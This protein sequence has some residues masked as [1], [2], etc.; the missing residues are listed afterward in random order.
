MNLY[1]IK[2]AEGEIG[3]KVGENDYFGVINIGNV[4]GFK[5]LLEGE[6]ISVEQ[7]VISGSLF[8]KI[9]EESSNINILIGSRKFIE[10]WD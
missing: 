4:S 1:E 5:R 7:D 3:L 9:K 2:N 8:D 6:G 10:G